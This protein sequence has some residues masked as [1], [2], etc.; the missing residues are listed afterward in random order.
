MVRRIGFTLVEL[1][2]AIAIIGI[3]IAVLLPAVNSAREAARLTQCRNH[4]RQISLAGNNF[5]NFRG[6]FP[7]H[8]GEEEPLAVLVI[9]FPGRPQENQDG[10]WMVQML[11]FMEDA[12]LSGQLARFASSERIPDEYQRA[13]QTPVSTFY[14]PSRRDAIAYPL[15]RS[16]KQRFGE[17]GARTDY[18]MNGGAPY[19]AHG[20]FLSVDKHGVWVFGHR[21]GDKQIRD[22]LSKTY[23]V[24][25]KAMEKQHYETGKD[26]GDLSPLAG[27]GSGA[28]N[29]YV[30]FAARPPAR[31]RVNNCL[32]CHD[33]GS[34]HLASWTVALCDGS[35]QSLSLEMDVSVH[36]ALASI[37]G[38]ELA[39]LVEAGL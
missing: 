3:L 33:F 26:R 8:G 21:V 1:L 10:T 12:Q 17:M 36:R 34:P 6:T 16:F 22:G 25:E 9:D 20:R 18:A 24:G 32:A 15:H 37:R 35:V 23:F 4:L 11:A 2:V 7:G 28:A 27:V 31:D 19:E 13:F 39:G 14:C 30:R 38:N 5:H 29:S